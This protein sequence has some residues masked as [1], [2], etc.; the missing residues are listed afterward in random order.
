MWNN[1]G[2]FKDQE[3]FLDKDGKLPKE[4][5]PDQ[6]H[7]SEKGYQIWTDAVKGPVNELLGK[8]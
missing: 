5:M 7:L 3:V 8:K 1:P 2:A 4:I 6:L